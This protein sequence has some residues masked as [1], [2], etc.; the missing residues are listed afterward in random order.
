[1]FP[2]L[3]KW[4]GKKKCSTNVVVEESVNGYFGKK[5]Y[6]SDVMNSLGKRWTRCIELKGDY[7][8]KFI[9]LEKMY[10]SL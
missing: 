6:F 2:N 3:K 8:E 7:V 4:F 5:T 9:L 10:F 1:L